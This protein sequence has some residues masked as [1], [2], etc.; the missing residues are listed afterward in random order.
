MATIEKYILHLINAIIVFCLASMMLMVFVN[1]VLRYGF[2]S[3]ITFSEEVSR[4]FFVWLTFLGAI[5]A[6]KDGTHIR[7]DSLVQKLSPA[8]QK[9]C[10]FISNALILYVCSFLLEGGWQQTVI[11]MDT[12]SPVTGW[13]MA[14]LYITSVIASIGIALYAIRNIINLFRKQDSQP[15]ENNV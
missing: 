4:L 2:N 7:V 14:S 6:M 1:V 3:G 5:A 10:A 15:E 13:P 9:A 12:V 11:N 8:G